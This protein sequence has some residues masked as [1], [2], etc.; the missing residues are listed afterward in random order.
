MKITQ[1]TLKVCFVVLLKNK[2]FPYG[3]ILHYPDIKIHRKRKRRKAPNKKVEL[4]VLL[5]T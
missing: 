2:P 3:K 4:T 5:A 1:F